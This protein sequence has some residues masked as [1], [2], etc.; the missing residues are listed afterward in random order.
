MR[1][2]PIFL[3]SLFLGCDS[4]TTKPSGDYQTGIDATDKQCAQL[5]KDL[6]KSIDKTIADLKKQG[7]DSSMIPSRSEIKKQFEGPL[8]ANGCSGY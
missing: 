2:F 4:N 8:K 5:K 6:E 3:A 7:M 1:P